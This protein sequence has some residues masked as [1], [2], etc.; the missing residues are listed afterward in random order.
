[1]GVTTVVVH[2]RAFD[3]GKLIEDTHDWFAQDQV[4]NVWYFGEDTST[5]KDGKIESHHGAWEAGVD[6]AL[7]G[8]VMLAQPVVGDL[9][10]QEFYAGEAEDQALVLEVGSTLKGTDRTYD[11]ILMTAD[12]TPLEPDQLEHKLYAR[13]VGIVEERTIKGGSGIVRI[14][15]EGRDPAAL[16]PAATFDP[17]RE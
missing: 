1:M 12:F 5:C 3:A 13:G 17:C 16:D 9:Y 11:D 2:D 4:G 7:P 6:G 14:V 15:S 8:I 10:R